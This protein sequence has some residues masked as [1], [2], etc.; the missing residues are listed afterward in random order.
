MNQNVNLDQKKFLREI[1]LNLLI[2]FF[3][4][5]TYFYI[6]EFFGSIS[7][8][9]IHN[10]DLLLNFHITLLIFTFLILLTKWYHG[11][12]AGFIGEYLY[13]LA[14]CENIYPHWILFVSLWGLLCGLL[15]YE[16][17]MYL[18]FKN[19]IY[20]FIALVLISITYSIFIIILV[21]ST[22]PYLNCLS[23]TIIRN[24]GFK[25]FLQTL[26]SI[27]FIVPF[28]LFLYDFVFSKKE[29]TIYNILFTHHPIYMSDH[30]FYLKFGNT[31]IYFCSRCSG[32]ILGGMSAFFSTHVFEKIFGNIISP[33]LAVILCILL[34]IPG[35]ADWGTQRLLLRKSTTESR[36][37]TGFIIGS[38]LHLLS[39]TNKYYLIMTFILILYFSILFGLMYLG[40]LRQKKLNKKE[41][42][43]QHYPSIGFK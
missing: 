4:I 2:S 20:I 34:P 37:L 10:K 26:T 24:Y 6:S 8:V 9:Y 23:E 32:V 1:F 17:N 11:F 38:A 21:S 41:E 25:F 36:L 14:F 39:Y 28:S 22:S 16:P 13:Q 18:S 19:V 5:S 33:E 7:S 40:Y 42:E 31:Y 30:T 29:R 43:D 15:K 35:L 27:I 12:I 3:L